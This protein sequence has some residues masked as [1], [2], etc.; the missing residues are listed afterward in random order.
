[1]GDPEDPKRSNKQAGNNTLMVLE[2]PLLPSEVTG[3]K[4]ILDFSHYL[5]G[6][7]LESKTAKSV[8]VEG[9]RS[10]KARAAEADGSAEE[11]PQEPAGKKQRKKN[12]RSHADM[13]DIK[14][15]ADGILADVMKD[16]EL[17]KMIEDSP[18]LKEVVKE[19]KA[20]PMAGLQ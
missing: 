2:V 17:A 15:Q 11:S 20:N 5:I 19:V 1:M 13:P 12:N 14:A 16:P 6:K 7:D 18:K 9:D 3:P 4:A 10:K 8:G